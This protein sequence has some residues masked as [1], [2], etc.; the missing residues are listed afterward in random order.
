M[1]LDEIK[2][3][4]GAQ[5]WAAAWGY[6][7]LERQDD[8][9][10]TNNGGPKREVY[11]EYKDLEHLKRWLHTYTYPPGSDEWNEHRDRL[12]KGETA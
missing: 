9:V 5:E 11:H 12:L 8:L 3:V 1:R 6:V 2:T 10:I 7:I 4:Q